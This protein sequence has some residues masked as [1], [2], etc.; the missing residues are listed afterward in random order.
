MQINIE[1][2]YK[3]MLPFWLRII[4]HVQSTQNKIAYLLNISRIAWWMKLLLPA[5][6]PKHF[7][8]VES[9]TLGVLVRHTHSIQNKFTTSLQHLKENVK[10]DV[11]FL[12]LG[13]RFLQSDTIILDECGQTCP[14]YPK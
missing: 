12:P 7:I 9:T 1:V 14:N 2:S 6:K 8:Q 10:D 5:Y 4:R 3:L 11:D 13:K